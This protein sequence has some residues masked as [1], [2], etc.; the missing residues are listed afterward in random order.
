VGALRELVRGTKTALRASQ[1]AISEYGK[2]DNDSGSFSNEAH[3][4]FCLSFAYAQDGLLDGCQ[5]TL[6]PVLALPPALRT[7]GLIKSMRRL[8]ALLQTSPYQTSQEARGGR[9]D[10]EAFVA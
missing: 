10:I 2:A 6:A 1:L 9:D 8:D 7:S 4:R 5:Q 3:S